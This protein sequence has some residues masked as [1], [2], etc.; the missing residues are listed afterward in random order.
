MQ[1][2]DTAENLRYEEFCPAG[3]RKGR[4]FIRPGLEN[5]IFSLRYGVA[6][7]RLHYTHSNRVLHLT[8]ADTLADALSP[9]RHQ[10]WG[11]AVTGL[12]T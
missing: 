6:D 4:I 3:K 12:Y 1:F 7:L 11:H 5:K 9:T 2:G 8:N 10:N